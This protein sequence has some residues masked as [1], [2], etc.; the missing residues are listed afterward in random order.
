[1]TLPPALEAREPAEARGLARDEVRLMVTFD[2][3][4]VTH[5]RFTRFPHF[6]NPGDVLVVNTSATIN[7]ALPATRPDG[8]PIALH[9]SQR[10]PG[11]QWVVELRRLAEHGSAPLLTAT[12][13]ERLALPAGGAAVLVAPY[14]LGGCARA[15][16]AAEVRLWLASLVVPGDVARYLDLHGA[17][18]RYG[19]VPRAWP[20]SYYQ[21]I[22]AREPGSAEMPS[23]GRAFTP[24][25]LAA[26]HAKGIVIAPIV[27]HTG[28]ASLEAHEPPYPEQFRVSARTAD[29]VN[30]AR[31]EGRRVIAVGTTAVRALESVASED[32]AVRAGQGWTDLVVTPERGLHVVD[33]LLTG[34]HEPRASHLAILEAL[35]GRRHVEVA[36]EA[37]LAGRYLWHEFG[38]LHFLLGGE[39][40]HHRARAPR[41]G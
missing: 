31:R 24:S 40:A 18:I 30:A 20:L 16:S 37:A 12:V 1:F 21:T 7:A 28:V 39:R 36:Y 32:G 8:E 17:P 38:D 14:R 26:L 6:V 3:G 10:L 15:R 11:G 9:L 27:L 34:F 19:Y 22:F 4:S 5:T 29:A 41:A 13:G 25:V 2:D 33:A 35:A 23:A